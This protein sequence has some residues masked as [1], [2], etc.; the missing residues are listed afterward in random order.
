MENLHNKSSNNLCDEADVL[1]IEGLDAILPCA[2]SFL[3][4]GSVLVNTFFIAT[5]HLISLSFTKQ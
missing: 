1:I 5:S 2:S 3:F 4:G